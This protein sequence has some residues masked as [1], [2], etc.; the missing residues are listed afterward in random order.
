VE[1]AVRHPPDDV[2]L[3]FN[4]DSRNPPDAPA[5]HR[6]ASILSDD[7]LDV[8][9][10]VLDLGIWGGRDVKALRHGSWG[11]VFGK[12]GDFGRNAIR[13]DEHG[14]LRIADV[15]AILSSSGPASEFGG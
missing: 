7:C 13:N 1:F 3:G 10:A 4:H 12:R 8:R 6:L 5:L 2:C 9:A 11:S 14:G 15:V